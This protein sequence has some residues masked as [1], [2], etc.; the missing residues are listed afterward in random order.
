M[1]KIFAPAQMQDPRGMCIHAFP[2]YQRP[3]ES[4]RRK[5][6]KNFP[7]L[8][9]LRIRAIIGQTPAGPP[10][11]PTKGRIF[12]QSETPAPAKK[13]K[14]HIECLRIL[15]IWLV[16]F[17]HSST[18]GFS[19]YLAQQD[20]PWFPFYLLVPFWVK[21]AVP[22]FFMVSGALLL[23]RDEP[24]SVIFRKRIWRFVQVLLVFS[25]INYLFFY[26]VPERHFS[27]L[28]FLSITYTSNMAT[29]YYFLYIY[30]SFLLMLPLWRAMVRNLTNAHY[31]Y[32]IGLNLFF[33]GCVPVFSFL[34]YRGQAEM[35]G[36]LNPLLAISEPSFYFIIGYWIE[37]VLPEAWLTKKNLIRL[38]LLAAAGTGIAAFMTWFYGYTAGALTEAIS[39]RFYDSFLFLN[40]AFV[41][42]LC[43]WWFLHHSVSPAWSGRLV[44]LGSLS[45]GVMLFEEITRAVTHRLLTQVLL[46]HFPSFPFID[47]VLWITA[48][49]TLG[50]VMTW[51]VKKVPY[52]KKLI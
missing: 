43:R 50:A 44:L 19:L 47:A 21:T 16:M 23:G 41:Y 45:F 12:V 1:E 32:L 38:G 24:I 37:N 13:K 42:C 6:R 46:P 8:R 28:R 52:F 31:L 17:T 48:A 9:R 34:L 4:A 39:Q 36:F 35:N 7:F 40:T 25:F 11:P 49:F 22:I 51:G 15:C 27:V 26:A 5:A 2:F 30:I 10:R 18:S 20:S 14:L 29:A 3:R 33:V